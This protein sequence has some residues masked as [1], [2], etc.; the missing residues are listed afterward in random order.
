[1]SLIYVITLFGEL[2]MTIQNDMD[3]A[4]IHYFNDLKMTRKNYLA[5]QLSDQSI[6]YTKL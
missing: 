1:M 6:K 4:G 5:S 3:Y 2:S